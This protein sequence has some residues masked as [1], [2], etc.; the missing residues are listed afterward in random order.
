MSRHFRLPKPS[1]TS[2]REHFSNLHYYRSRAGSSIDGK[3]RS[4]QSRSKHVTCRR[5]LGLAPCFIISWSKTN[6]SSLSLWR[7]QVGL[8]PLH[9]GRRYVQ[10]LTIPTS[11]YNAGLP[12]LQQF[13]SQIRHPYISLPVGTPAASSIP[14]SG[15]RRY[16]ALRIL[17]VRKIRMAHR[18][19]WIR[20][21]KNKW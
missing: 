21:R 13:K 11:A 6:I 12:A 9:L 18:V 14:R 7:P 1:Q 5:D 10:H 17:R 20:G 2:T 4:W 8:V 16:G 15:A 3:G 19:R